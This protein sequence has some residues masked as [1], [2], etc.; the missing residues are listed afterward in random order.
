MKWEEKKWGEEWEGKE[1]R[2]FVEGVEK[3]GVFE[4]LGWMRRG[5]VEGGE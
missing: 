3:V 4:G 5:G 1:D 2:V